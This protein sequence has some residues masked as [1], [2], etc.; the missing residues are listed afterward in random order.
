MDTFHLLLF[1]DR[2][3]FLWFSNPPRVDD[4]DFSAFLAFKDSKLSTIFCHCHR[5]LARE[6]VHFI[7][8]VGLGRVSN[9]DGRCSFLC[10]LLGPYTCKTIQIQPQDQPKQRVCLLPTHSTGL[11]SLELPH[12]LHRCLLFFQ[13]FASRVVVTH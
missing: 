13:Y 4:V 7:Q 12:S 11:Q 6:K 3:F 9:L 1:C 10:V 8:G 5:Q 2:F